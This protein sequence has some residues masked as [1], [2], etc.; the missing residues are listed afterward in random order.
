MPIEFLIFQWRHLRDDSLLDLLAQ[1]RLR[2]FL[3]LHKDHGRDLLGGE[4]LLLAK[5]VNLDEGGAVLVDNLERPMG[6]VLLDVG[7]AGKISKNELDAIAQRKG[8][9]L[10]V[11]P[12]DETLSIEN[13][14][15]GKDRID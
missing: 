6:H 1:L 10:L 14:S 9:V 2:D 5:V 4:G 11:S 7:V 8:T 13:N 3:H 12:A 15:R